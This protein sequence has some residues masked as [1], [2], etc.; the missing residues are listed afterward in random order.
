MLVCRELGM[1][2]SKPATLLLTAILAVSSIITVKTLLAAEK[3][4]FRYHGWVSSNFFVLG[5]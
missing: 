2:M 1:G 5:H 3:Q 4:A